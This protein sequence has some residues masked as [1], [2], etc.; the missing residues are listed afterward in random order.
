MKAHHWVVLGLAACQPEFSMVMDEQPGG[1]LLGGWS[2]GDTLIS[3][4]GQLS[5]SSGSIV[6]Y[7][8][9]SWCVSEGVADQALWWIHGDGQGEWYAVG[10]KGTILHS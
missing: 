8:G 7:D 5:G 3:V 2:D 4:G 6:E 10:E 1:I 9:E